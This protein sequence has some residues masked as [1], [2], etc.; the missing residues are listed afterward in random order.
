[1]EIDTVCIVGVGNVG[2]TIAYNILTDDFIIK[3][4]KELIL[5]DIDKSR[6][7]S[8]YKDLISAYIIKSKNILDKIDIIKCDSLFPA[9]VYIITAGESKY[10][11]SRDELF[12]KNKKIVENILKEIL[13]YNPDAK[14]IMVT[15]PSTRLVKEVGLNYFQTVIPIGLQLDNARLKA[16]I[17]EITNDS[18]FSD[19]Y[20]YGEHGNLKF[21]LH[22]IIDTEK[23]NTI[24]KKVNNYAK[25]I[26]KAKG[27]TNWGVATEVCE[28]LKEWLR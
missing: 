10:I 27:Y 21:A 14:I 24:I 13:D 18:Y 23:K 22:D 11:K 7:E 8:E 17:G 25:E 19:S 26:K 4:I 1:M 28:I 5:C 6:L 20:V 2:S 3:K 16:V 15:N 9:D 12:E